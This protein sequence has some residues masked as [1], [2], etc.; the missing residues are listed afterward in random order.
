GSTL[1]NQLRTGT[2]D[3]NGYFEIGD[4]P[5]GPLTFSTVDEDGR[6]TYAANQIRTAGEVITQ[7]LV[8]ERRAFPGLGVVRVTV[9][10][11]DTNEVVPNAHVGV[12]TQGYGLAEAYSDTNGFAEFPKVPAGLISILAAN[13]GISRESVGIELELRADQVLE[14]TIIIPVPP[15]TGTGY[16][17]LEGLITRDDPASPGDRSKDA[18]VPNAIITIG[19]LPPVTANADGT[20][21]FPD[22]PIAASGKQMLVFDPATGRKGT[23]TLPTL[24]VGQA[25]RFSPRLSSAEPEGVA[26]IRVRLTSATGEP[27]AGYRV[28]EPG[29]PLTVFAEKGNGIYELAGVQVP[30]RVNIVAVPTNPNGTYGEQMGFG[31][32]RVDFAGQVSTVDMRLPGQGIIITRLE[33]RQSQDACPTSAPCYTQAFGKVAASYSVWDEVEQQTKTKIVILDADPSTQLNTFRKIPALQQT[34]V[35]TD[36]HPAGHAGTMVTLAYE[37]D[38][39]N[40]TLRMESLGDVTGRVFAH[41]RQTPI[42]GALVKLTNANVI[43][44]TEATKPDGSFRFAAVQANLGFRLIA[45]YTQD[46]IY[47]K[48]Y[49]DGQTPSGGGPVSNLTIV[50]REQS[51]IEGQVIDVNGDP[52]PLARYWAREL[53]WPYTTYGTQHDPLHADINGRFI[54]TNVFTG[55]F[56]ITAVSPTVQEERG[57]YQGELRFEGDTSQ[58]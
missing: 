26:T 4:L 57:D 55:P 14:Q 36:R 52:V 1:F 8:I 33:L 9:R 7:D 53:A 12:Y 54:L 34:A 39:R 44:G 27:V 15:P 46:G 25:N 19:K 37:G 13:F 51:T 3:D 49:A 6:A 23:F 58:L 56:R 32:A 29:F 31:V 10:R 47:R 48:G 11:S 40:I 20:Y 35:Y 5:V 18:V 21:V 2:T 43:Y 22:L 38:V 41:D 16:I 24:Q 50:M 42:N 28:I 17:T 30:G 45:E